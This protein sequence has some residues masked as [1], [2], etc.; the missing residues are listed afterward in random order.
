VT[1]PV[2]VERPADLVELF[3]EYR[4]TGARHIRNRIVEA[5]LDIPDYYVRR[6]AGKGVASDDLR[7]TALLTMV[8]AVERYDP[9]LGVEFSTF[10]GRTI[11]GELKRYFRDRTWAV[12]PPRRTQELHLDLRRAGEELTHELGRAP[13]VQELADALDET[14]DHV[15]EALEAGVAHRANSLDQP[16]SGDDDA[17]APADRVLA[18]DEV[19]YEWIDRRMVVGELLD[20]LDDR[21][22]E[23]IAMRFF[24]GMS[25]PEI[26][27]RIGVSQSYLSRLLR[28][29]LM[30]L[31]QSLPED[32][33]ALED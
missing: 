27:E 21:E 17:Q 14:V 9:E 23:I 8:R 33:G 11:D 7:Q 2:T 24:E 13:T 16:I 10:A 26:A 32:L 4:R 6:F 31:R 29:T 20:Q 5:H 18:S 12:R 1:V 15:L 30:R 3:R 19:G 28:K 25:Q 22:R